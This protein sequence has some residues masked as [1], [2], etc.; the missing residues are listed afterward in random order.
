MRSDHY[1]RLQTIVEE[2]L[3][4][5]GVPASQLEED[6][7]AIV[8]SCAAAFDQY[9][10]LGEDIALEYA[11]EEIVELENRLYK[12]RDILELLHKQDHLLEHEDVKSASEKVLAQSALLFFDERDDLMLLRDLYDESQLFFLIQELEQTPE[13]RDRMRNVSLVIGL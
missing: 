2:I 12:L 6:S 11:N 13:F 9:K 4:D 7:L 1:V 3:T 10:H 8:N 5:L